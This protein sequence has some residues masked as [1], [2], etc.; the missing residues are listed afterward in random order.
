[1]KLKKEIESKNISQRKYCEM[2]RISQCYLSNFLNGKP[3]SAAKTDKIIMSA[4]QFKTAKPI[5]QFWSITMQKQEIAGKRE[6]YI[7][8]PGRDWYQ[9]LKN[10]EKELEK[11][12]SIIINKTERIRNVEL[13]NQLNRKYYDKK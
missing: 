10:A 7:Y 12:F 1:M 4:K 3:Q 5:M 2:Y 13:N 9:A 6:I 11:G 8:I